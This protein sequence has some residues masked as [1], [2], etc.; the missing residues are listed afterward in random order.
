MSETFEST[1]VF[2]PQA[3]LHHHVAAD[4]A[5]HRDIPRPRGGQPVSRSAWPARSARV[6][7]EGKDYV[8]RDGDVVEFRH[9]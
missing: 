3:S 7:M 4:S 6:G 2:L 5:L 9:G 1:T 8:M